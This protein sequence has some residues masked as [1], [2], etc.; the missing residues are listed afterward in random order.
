[1]NA[2]PPRAVAGVLA[3][4][5]TVLLATGCTFT[6]KAHAEKLLVGAPQG[7]AAQGPI[8]VRVTARSTPSATAK[9]AGVVTD[10]GLA[11]SGTLDLQSEQASY[12]LTGRNTPYA[13]FDGLSLYG[14]RPGAAAD[15]ARP[16][17][18]LDASSVSSVQRVDFTAQPS[19][20]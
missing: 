11:V 4:A 13:V 2:L 1:M 7:L 20:A 3:A 12:T 17:V 16:W 8:Q 6:A 5:A 10:P 18:A 19:S 15:D 14:R 9:R